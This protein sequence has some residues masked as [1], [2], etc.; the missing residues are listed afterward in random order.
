MRKRLLLC[1]VSLVIAL[2]VCAQDNRG[3]GFSPEKFQADLEQFI[4]KEAGLTNKE[5]EKFFPL[6]DEMRK[7][8][9]AKF[10]RIRQ[11]SRNNPT[12]DAACLNIIKQCDKLE[13]DLKRIQ[14][15]YHNKFLTVIPARK[16]LDVIKA[17]N[18]FHRRS[19]K[20]MH[21]NNQKK[22]RK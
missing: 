13:I 17:E 15:S 6:Y 20:K 10:D 3:K 16:L 2:S 8:Q 19:L 12:D 7:A 14:Q 9:R 11:L 1:F 18:K 5:A 22:G 4:I 21:D